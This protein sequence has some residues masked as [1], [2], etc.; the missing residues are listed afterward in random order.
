MK[1][2]TRVEFTFAGSTQKG[3]VKTPY[4][5]GTEEWVI[6]LGDDGNNYPFSK[7]DLSCLKVIN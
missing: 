1:K 7:K 3:T 4:K 5:K 6:I 2:G